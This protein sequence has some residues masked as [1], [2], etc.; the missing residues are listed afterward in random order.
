MEHSTLFAGSVTHLSSQG[1]GVVPRD[2]GTRAL[3]RGV[4]P[5]DQGLFR[6][7]SEYEGRYPFAELVELQVPS[8]ERRT[9]PCPHSGV[10][11]CGGCPWMLAPYAAQLQQK[12]HR[13]Q[14]ALTR[15]GFQDPPM[16]PIWPSP[17]EFGYRSRAQWKT[18][19]RIMGYASAQGKSI[20]PI[21]QCPVLSPRLQKIVEEVQ[22]SLPREDF[23]PTG[24]HI[25]SFLDLDETVEVDKLVLNRRRAFSQANQ[26]QNEQM[27]AWL[28]LRA[29][30]RPGETQMLELFAGS[31]NFT[32]VLVPLGYQHILALEVAPSAVEALSAQAWPAV[33]AL[34]QDLY[35]PRFAKKLAHLAKACR[36]VLV[37]PPRAGLM[38]LAR[39]LARDLP[40][41]DRVLYV[42]CDP[43][44]LANDLRML[45]L[46]GFTLNEVQ[47]LDQMP[48]TPHIEI[49]AALSRRSPRL[50]S[51]DN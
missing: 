21:T 29:A 18:D 34:R 22:A 15:A 17:Q 1:Y 45:R 30:P 31:G 5:G 23:A 40:D 41:L 47:A 49:L 2:D 25:W 36:T 32:E 7:T 50:A 39:T 27:R 14:Y 16:A 6:L 13:V 10:K 28:R 3:V 42:S 4:W 43:Q 37:N 38:H 8:S 35:H 48:H 51:L 26:A 24:D 12:Q 19:G 11:E 20:V 33:E 9:P 44:S 46:G